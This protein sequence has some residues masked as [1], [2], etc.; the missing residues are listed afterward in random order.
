MA[1]KKKTVLILGAGA[2]MPYG[3]PSGDE[4]KQKIISN[5]EHFPRKGGPGTQLESIMRE[6]RL[7]DYH[8]TDFRDQ[9]A[10]APHMTIDRFLENRPEFEAIGKLAIA[11]TLIPLEVDSVVRMFEPWKG[12]SCAEDWY[13]YFAQH[14]NLSSTYWGDGLLTIITYNYDRSLEYFLFRILKSTCRKSE[15]ECRDIFKGIPII[16]IYG[17]LGPYNPIG[18][19]LPYGVSLNSETARAAANNIRIMHEAK[20]EGLTNQSKTAVEN[21]EVV[22]FLGFGYHEENLTPL[23]VKSHVQGKRVLGTAWDLTKEERSRLKLGLYVDDARD[24][25]ILELLRKSDVLG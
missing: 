17:E 2:S 22:C 23:G 21:A 6:A 9:L 3:F 14:L 15:Q 1:L 25:K 18:R 16:H 8:V 24:C 5:L 20:D 4:L 7:E 19:G 10:G 11:A 12:H 13:T